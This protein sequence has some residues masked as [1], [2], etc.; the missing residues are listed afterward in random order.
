MTETATVRPSSR[1]RTPTKRAPAP[2]P[3]NTWAA[4]S[5]SVGGRE[6]VSP[7]ICAA[8]LASIG[9]TICQAGTRSSFAAPPPTTA[10]AVS[11]IQSR[12][13][14]S[15]SRQPPRSGGGA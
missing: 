8:A 7:P 15:V 13:L 1:G 9:P 3:M 5:N 4:A 11:T 14:R 12:R 6:A 10:D 2:Q